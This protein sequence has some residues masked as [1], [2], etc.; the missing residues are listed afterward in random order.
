MIA[1]TKTS[2]SKESR[3]FTLV[4]MLV[5]IGMIGAL[6][7]IS[8]PVYKSIQKKVEKQQIQM[9]YTSIE[10]AVDNFETEYNYMPHCE[11]QYPAGDS[12]YY[13]LNSMS[14][15]FLGILMGLESDKNFKKIEFLEIE[16]AEG[17]GPGSTTSK[18]PHGYRNGV[19]IS[20]AY[21]TLYSPNG[22]HYAYRLDLNGDGEIANCRIGW[23]GGITNPMVQGKRI[24][25]HTV[26][27]VIWGKDYF[28]TNFD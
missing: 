7:G 21:A 26:S 3:G 4:E 5:V 15:Q 17:S 2:Q 27:G 1:S 9:M 6:A 22:M 25:L 24:A 20:G 14:S 18:G 12:Q 19:K 23:N 13:W 11:A 10:R 16:E 8:F 28:V